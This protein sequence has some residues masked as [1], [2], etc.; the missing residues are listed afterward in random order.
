MSFVAVSI[1]GAALGFIGSIGKG[2][3]RRKANRQL[4]DL[5]KQDPVYSKN[6]LAAQRL[7]LAQTMLNSRMPG[8]ASVEKNIYGTQAN[9]ASNV[10]RNATDASQALAV[11]AG[12]QGQS[13]QAFN[14]LGV[15]EAKYFDTNYQNL[16]DAQKGQI[17]EDDKFFQDQVRRFGDLSQ[18]KGAKSA[19]N[20]NG[21]QDVSNLG[22]GLGSFGINSGFGFKQKQP[23]RSP[24]NFF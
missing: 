21:W 12:L 23:T 22:F 16:I 8:A 14:E 18:I 20:M 17:N 6:P 4:E 5:I 11:N 19:N 2:A 10:N 15:N 9:A 13:D 3:A 7:G 1:G 24:G